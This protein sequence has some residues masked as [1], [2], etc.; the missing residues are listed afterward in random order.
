M[1][2][3][4]L[5]NACNN[6]R[7]CYLHYCRHC[8]HQS[9]LRPPL[10]SII[11]IIISHHLPYHHYYY[12]VKSGSG[13]YGPTSWTDLPVVVVNSIS[14]IHPPTPGLWGPSGIDVGTNAICS[15]YT[16]HFTHRPPLCFW[17]PRVFLLIA[18]LQRC[19]PLSGVTRCALVAW[20]SERSKH[21]A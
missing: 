16:A 12:Y 15:P 14:S 8:C 11:V 2:A 18:F 7:H 21:G 17:P 9:L 4:T 13:G 20:D 5:I 3:D 19:S 1:C 10:P 6:Y